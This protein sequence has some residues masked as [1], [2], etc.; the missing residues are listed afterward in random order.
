MI[1]VGVVGAGPVAQAIHLPT[2]ARLGGRAAITHVMDPDLQLA[3]AVAAPLGAT[4]VAD[5]DA[6]LAARPDVV[7]IGSPDAFHADQIVAAC[8]AGVRGILAEKPLAASAADAARVVDAVR[9]SGVAFVVGAMHTYD[10]AWLGASSAFA[11]AGPFHVRSAIHIPGNARFED[12]ATTMIR[13]AAVPRPAASSQQRLRGGVLGLAIHNLPL[14]RHFVPEISAVSFAA[15]TDPW[16]YVIAASGPRGSVEFLARIGGPWRPD[17]TLTVWGRDAELALDFPPS[18]VHGGSAT[19]SV[20]VGGRATVWPS[21]TVD[22]Y[23]AEWHELLAQLDGRAPRYPVE[24]LAD[25]L[26]YAL[27]LADLTADA[28]RA[29]ELP[30]AVPSSAAA[31]TP[32]AAPAP[33]APHDPAGVGSSDAGTFPSHPE[34]GVLAVRAVPAPTPSLVAAVGALPGRFRL[35]PATHGPHVAWITDAPGWPEVATAAL[36]AGAVAVVLGSTAAL[37]ADDLAPFAGRRV[38]LAGRR[39]HAPQV[40]E[41]ASRLPDLGPL[42]FVEVLVVDGSTDPF[43]PADALFDTVAMLTRAGLPL[44]TVPSIGVGG[45]SL[46]VDAVLAGARAHLSVVHRPGAASRAAIKAF[47]ARGSLEATM[48]D[49]AIAAP[50]SVLAVTASGARQFPTR[51]VTP[52]GVVLDEVGAALAQRLDPPGLLELHAPAAGLLGQVEWVGVEQTTPTKL[53]GTKA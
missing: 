15:T 30:A 34:D 51:Y 40:L 6:L 18:Y 41:F 44:D 1:E 45:G 46:V 17:W 11:D 27:R 23:L 24:T 12:M 29:S 31:P 43:V 36:D 37:G 47:S 38:V 5:L 52:L 8:A 3:R 50:G 53:E 10:P 35:D 7:V 39:T 33:G 49:P 13:P 32:A 26:L 4:A 19:A 9:R 22:G 48:G 21:G 20:T 25:D 16:G 42:D 28:L 14:V 2:I